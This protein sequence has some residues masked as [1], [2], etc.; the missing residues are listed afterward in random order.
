MKPGDRVKATFCKRSQVVGRSFDLY[1]YDETVVKPLPWAGPNTVCLKAENHTI[2]NFVRIVE[3]KDV[4]LMYVNGKRVN[5][6]ELIDG[7]LN[8]VVKIKG[9][10]GNEY[11]VTIRNGTPV[12][13]DCTGYSFRKK[14]R[15][16]NDAVTP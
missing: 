15:H 6:R 7:T 8:K 3:L 12:N 2:P 9:S 13:C 1:T 5:P 10:K 14:C 11:N 16:L 4:A